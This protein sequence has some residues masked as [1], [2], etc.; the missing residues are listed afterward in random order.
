MSKNPKNW[1]KLDNI[2]R[3]FLHIFWKTW[4]DSMKFSGKMCL[5]IILKLTKNQGFF[6]SLQDTLFRKPQGGWGE[7]EVYNRYMW[8]TL[9]TYNF[10]IYKKAYLQTLKFYPYPQIPLWPPFIL[11][12]NYIKNHT[13]KTQTFSITLIYTKK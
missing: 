7:G 4:G 6:L 10:S 5:K 9:L 8:H 11:K 3:E 13:H 12:I 1:W 2:D